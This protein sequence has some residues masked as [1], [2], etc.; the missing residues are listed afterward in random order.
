MLSPSTQ[1][2]SCSNTSSK[3]IYSS[4][5]TTKKCLLNPT[6]LIKR[7]ISSLKRVL[8]FSHFSV[9]WGTLS[10]VNPYP[11][12]RWP[13][14]SILFLFLFLVTSSFFF[15]TLYSFL[16]TKLLSSLGIALTRFTFILNMSLL[17]FSSSL[18]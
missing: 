9:H 1:K 16:V 17:H 18:S 8:P 10:S 5:F 4:N 12:S 11:A 15:G 6:N 13:S 7:V 3:Y 2:K 14:L